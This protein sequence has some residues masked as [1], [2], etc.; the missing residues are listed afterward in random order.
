MLTRYNQEGS[1]EMFPPRLL[2][3]IIH[4]YIGMSVNVKLFPKLAAQA[5]APMKFN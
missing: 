3:C 4:I 5:L 2:P 1:A